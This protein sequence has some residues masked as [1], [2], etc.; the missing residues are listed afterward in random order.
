M[1]KE[2]GRYHLDWVIKVNF[3]SCGTGQH[4]VYPEGMY[5]DSP[6]SFL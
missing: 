4:H 1:V 3:T 6:T 2:P 5:G